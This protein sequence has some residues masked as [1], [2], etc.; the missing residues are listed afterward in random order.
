MGSEYMTSGQLLFL[1]FVVG[2]VLLF[3]TAG[4]WPFVE[5]FRWLKGSRMSHYL[6]TTPGY[7]KVYT[8]HPGYK[9]RT[10]GQRRSFYKIKLGSIIEISHGF[11][12]R[13]SAIYGEAAK[14]WRVTSDR[15]WPNT[16]RW[17]YLKDKRGMRIEDALPLINI[18]PSLQ[19]MLDRIAEL[20]KELRS[21]E[22]SLENRNNRV[23]ELEKDLAHAEDK[24]KQWWA[25]IKAVLCIINED[26]PRYRSTPAKHIREYLESVDEVAQDLGEPQPS[27]SLVERAK[28]A[29]MCFM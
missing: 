10:E 15:A 3:L 2:L 16:L 1:I 19:A 4:K 12:R 5:F 26:K 22:A 18:Y 20:E 11:L 23:L 17:V 28:N 27:G 29:L 24:R 14:N 25:T 6:T 8:T 21:T 13:R 7:E 9:L